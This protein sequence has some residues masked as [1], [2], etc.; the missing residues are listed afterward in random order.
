M[1]RIA[2]GASVGCG[3]PE[4]GIRSPDGGV[5]GVLRVSMVLGSEVFALIESTPALGPRA[6]TREPL[7]W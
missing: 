7:P 4:G 5:T 1:V 2:Q 6:S 3:G